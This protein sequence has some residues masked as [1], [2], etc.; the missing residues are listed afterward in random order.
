MINTTEKP[1]NEKSNI[2][3]IDKDNELSQKGKTSHNV[4]PEWPIKDSAQDTSQKK[5]PKKS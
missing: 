1:K 5:D 3:Q 4:E 2:K